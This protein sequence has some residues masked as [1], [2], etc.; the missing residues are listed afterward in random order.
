VRRSS[1]AITRGLRTYAERIYAETVGATLASLDGT[2]FRGADMKAL[3]RVIAE[4]SMNTVWVLVCDAA[5]ARF[6]EVRGGDPAWHLVSDVS[7]D[8]SRR[9]ATDLVS[10]KAGRASSEGGSVHHNALAPASSPKQ[11]QKEHF[12]HSLGKTLDQ[13]MRSARFHRWVLVAPPHFLGMMEKELT[14]ELK[15]H[16][17][18]TVDKEM[19]HLGPR[20]LAEKLQHAV[21]IPPDQQD[22]VRATSKHPH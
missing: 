12:A 1:C 2:R 21:V 6:F 7:H 9:K 14:A 20:E 19:S 18:T 17:L 22:G 10:D 16:L 8:E 15:K 13:A 11:I 4:V 3:L 5:R